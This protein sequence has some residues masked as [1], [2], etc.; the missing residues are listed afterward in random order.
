MGK[1]ITGLLVIGGIWIASELFMYGPSNAFGG[2]LAG[3]MGSGSGESA[4]E[5]DSRSTAR[6]AG[7][8]VGRA[9]A[10][11]EARRDRLLAE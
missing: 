1:V 9:Q 8:A 11:A 3:L 4:Q 2:A 6:R 5:I 7:D 10:E